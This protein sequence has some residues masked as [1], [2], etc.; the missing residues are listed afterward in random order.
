[1]TACCRSY[2][3]IFRDLCKRPEARQPLGG[4]AFGAVL[5]RPAVLGALRRH[6]GYTPQ[7]L[8]PPSAGAAHFGLRRPRGLLLSLALRDGAETLSGTRP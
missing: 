8:L 4:G 3:P 7:P 5:D 6:Y 1:M 2:P